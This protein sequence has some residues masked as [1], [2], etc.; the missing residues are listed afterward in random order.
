MCAGELSE[1]YLVYFETEYNIVRCLDF[2]TG[3]LE[4]DSNHCTLSFGIDMEDIHNCVYNITVEMINGAGRT[5]SSGSI[6]LCKGLHVHYNGSLCG[7][8]SDTDMTHSGLQTNIQVVRNDVSVLCTFAY[9][10]LHQCYILVIGNTY[11]EAVLLE[12][13][14]SANHTFTNLQSGIYT[15]LIYSVE[16]GYFFIPTDKPDYFTIVTFNDP[17]QTPVA[18]GTCKLI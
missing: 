8:I 10:V 9:T 4:T 13:E 5:N 14:K 17:L 18:H 6:T 12:G 2:V 3:L 1:K 11:Y 7:L 16:E 15:I